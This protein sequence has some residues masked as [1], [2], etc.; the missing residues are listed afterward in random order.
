M[1]SVTAAEIVANATLSQPTEE[2][3][4]FLRAMICYAAGSLIALGASGR[5]M[6]GWI[7]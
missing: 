6:G 3:V 2:R 7:V 5:D 4:D 1:R